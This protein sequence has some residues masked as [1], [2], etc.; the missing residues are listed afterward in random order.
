[1]VFSLSALWW[2]RIRGLWKLPDGRDLLRGKLGLVLMSGAMLSKS[3]IQFSV[4]GW[5]CVP[6]LLFIWGQTYKFEVKASACNAGDLGLIPGSGRSPGEGNGNPLQY[7]C[8]EYPTDGGAWRATV[9]RVEKSW[10][11]LNNFTFTF[12]LTNSCEKKKR[13][14]ISIWMQS[15]KE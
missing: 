4:D 10:T 9:H 7:S 2:R 5:S 3:L 6:S 1:M 12:K 14:D 13:K 8:L 11:R 15:S